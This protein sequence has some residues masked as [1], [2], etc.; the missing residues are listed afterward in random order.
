M[1]RGWRKPLLYSTL[2]VVRAL[3]MLI[4]RKNRYKWEKYES[5]LKR[6]MYNIKRKLEGEF[7]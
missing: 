5:I 7:I 1:R 4:G 6:S 2:D 3:F